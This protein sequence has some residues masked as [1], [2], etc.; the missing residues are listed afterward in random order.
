[1]DIIGSIARHGTEA[2]LEYRRMNEIETDERVPK[3]S[4]VDVS[5]SASIV[6]RV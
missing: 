2:V 1:M 5:L 6:I 3:S 4:W